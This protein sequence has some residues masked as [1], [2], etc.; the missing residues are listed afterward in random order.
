MELNDEYMKNPKFMNLQRSGDTH[1]WVETNWLTGKK[2]ERGNR[3]AYHTENGIRYSAPSSVG[4]RSG[5]Y[6]D[7][8]EGLTS[9][10][11]F[12]MHSILS[13]TFFAN[14]DEAKK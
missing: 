8:N 9:D 10:N 7:F 14:S 1:Y 13:Y 12:G 11:A 3:G 5:Q 4:L 2:E 6:V